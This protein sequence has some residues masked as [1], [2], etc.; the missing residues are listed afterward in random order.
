VPEAL[1]SSATGAL[2][3]KLDS[4]ANVADKM[5]SKMEHRAAAALG[6]MSS[7]LGGMT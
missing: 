2:L 7:R 3:S 6:G 1:S 5:Q 4:M